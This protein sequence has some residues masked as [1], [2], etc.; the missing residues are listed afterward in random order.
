[1]LFC[2][3]CQ[4]MYY[5]NIIDDGNT[6]Q[7]YC[8][9]CGD[10]YDD[11]MTVAHLLVSKT[12]IQSSTAS[13]SSWVNEYTKHDP[14]LMRVGNIPCVNVEC[15]TNMPDFPVDTREIIVIRYDTSNVKFLYLCAECDKVW[16]P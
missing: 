14:T 15:K 2:K 7:Y 4:N 8:R 11:D 12:N 5:I 3:S 6:L 10:I 16:S 9:T 13:F 1:M